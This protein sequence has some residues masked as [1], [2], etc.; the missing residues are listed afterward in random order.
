MTAIVITRTLCRISGS[1]KLRSYEKLKEKGLRKSMCAPPSFLSHQSPGRRCL[2]R[3]A[4][5]AGRALRQASPTLR[6]PQNLGAQVQ[7]QLHP[8]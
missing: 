5:A 4:E 2:E 8:C 1:P 6:A 7:R 3:G